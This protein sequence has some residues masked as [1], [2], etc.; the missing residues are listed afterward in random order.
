M[1]TFKKDSK[2]TSIKGNVIVEN[3][4]N[5]YFRSEERLLVGIDVQDLIV[6]ETSDAI[7]ISNKDSAQ[8][9]KNI[10]QKLNKSNSEEGTK[11]KKD[12]RPWGSFTSI[13]KQSNW[14]VKK[15][16]IKPYSSISLQ[17]HNHRFEHWIIVKG[18]AK[19]E[20]DKKVLFLKTNESIYVPKKSKHR[21]TNLV[22]K[23]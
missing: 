7:L 13:E 23:N 18:T 12:Y 2:G 11:N 14:Q 17:M 3:A 21:L 16:E 4:K 5:C 8:K 1:G 9:V 19:V 15:L 6:V 22:Q 20:I 10:V